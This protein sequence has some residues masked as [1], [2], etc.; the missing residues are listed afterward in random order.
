[1]IDEINLKS[2][3]LEIFKYWKSILFINISF[4]F[5]GISLS[6]YINPIYK[7]DALL[8]PVN[9]DSH[10]SMLA[11]SNINFLSNISGLSLNDKSYNSPSVIIATI[12]SREFVERIIDNELMMASLLAFSSYD[13]KN[14]AI[15]YDKKLFDSKEKKFFL[16]DGSTRPNLIDVHNAF[17]NS[18]NIYYDNKTNIIRISISHISPEFA[19]HLLEIVIQEIDQIYR[20]TSIEDSERALKFLE[21]ES[22]NTSYNDIKS[23]IN[24]LQTTHIENIMLAK[25][26]KEFIVKVVDKPFLPIYPSKMNKYL[27]ILVIFFIGFTLSLIYPSFRMYQRTY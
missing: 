13:S 18:L 14:K 7:S 4:I 24:I 25:S 6:A 16:K 11:N 15:I 5:I 10:G 17:L 22:I 20:K 3:F 8:I 27:F 21:N 1:M 26:K 19:K 2:F 9:A 12:K 23:S